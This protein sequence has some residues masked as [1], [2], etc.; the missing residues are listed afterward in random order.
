MN[1]LSSNK[2]LL[3]LDDRTFIEH[4]VDALRVAA[5]A[6]AIS[7]SHEEPFSSLGLPVWPDVHAGCGPLAGIH[8][9]ML[10]ARTGHLMVASCDSPLLTGS[11]ARDLASAAMPGEITI[12]SDG[13]RLQPLLGIYPV[14]R[15]RAV[16]EYLRGG[17][18]SVL[19][20]LDSAERPAV[21]LPRPEWSERLANINAPTDARD[22]SRPPATHC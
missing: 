7:A 10:R 4:V 17:G 15:V 20:F 6:M 13:V 12:V 9:A 5:G 14:E 22:L 3:L 2:A 8:A 19:G 1:V 16:D 11:M 21:V 18:R